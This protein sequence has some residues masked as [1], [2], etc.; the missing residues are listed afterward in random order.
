ME[1]QRIQ[2]IKKSTSSGSSTLKNPGKIIQVNHIKGCM[3]TGYTKI[4]QKPI[5]ILQWADVTK[6]LRELIS[7][8]EN[9][10]YAR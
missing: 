6:D 7:N 2:Q 8:T 9:Y 1:K 4:T 3:V 5:V 10:L